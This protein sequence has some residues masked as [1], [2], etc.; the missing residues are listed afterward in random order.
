VLADERGVLR[1]IRFPY[2]S[3]ITFELYA[4]VDA[5]AL[6]IPP[7]SVAGARSMDAELA[8]MRARV[9]ALIAEPE[10]RDRLVKASGTSDE[11]RP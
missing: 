4:G 3:T 6:V 8:A 10:F 11:R 9:D 2:G 1:G 7:A 5:N